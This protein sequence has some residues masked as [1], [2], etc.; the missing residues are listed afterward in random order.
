MSFCCASVLCIFRNEYYHALACSVFE[1][2]VSSQSII[3]IQNE[4]SDL[5]DK[6]QSNAR[7]RLT[8]RCKIE[9]STKG[10]CHMP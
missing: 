10:I 6:K 9:Q 4:F 5:L 1:I 8:K 7:E 3:L 2:N